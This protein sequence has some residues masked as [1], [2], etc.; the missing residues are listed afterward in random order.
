MGRGKAEKWV[1][2]DSKKRLTNNRLNLPPSAFSVKNGE[3]YLAKIGDLKLIWSRELSTEPSSVTVVKD[4]AGRY[5]L[6]FVVE[7][8]PNPV[9]AKNAHH[10]H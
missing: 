3:V 9:N 8:K 7:T 6:S 2:L 10:W 4:C 5:F 1:F